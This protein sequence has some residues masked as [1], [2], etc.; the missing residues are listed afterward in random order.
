MKY[1]IKEYVAIYDTPSKKQQELAIV[2]QIINLLNKN[3]YDNLEEFIK[4]NSTYQDFL[5]K[6]N[7]TNVVKHFGNTLKEADYINILENLRKLT[8]SKMNFDK[9]NLTTTNI[10][11][12]E[13]NTYTSENKN[14]F[15]DNSN[16]DKSIEEQMKDLQHTEQK[17]QTSNEKTNTENMLKELE[18]TKKESLNLQQLNQINFSNL[19]Q[20]QKEYFQVALN[21]QISS[22]ETLK[23]D[24]D[25][26][27]I[28]DQNNKIFKIT[29]NE[30]GEYIVITD[31][32]EKKEVNQNEH[33]QQ[34]KVHQKSL[35]PNPNT[36]FSSNNK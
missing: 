36:I 10:E 29:K 31:N 35:K 30:F 5:K 18:K 16:S 9:E 20:Q 24:L 25:R 1:N 17:F 2:S 12:K 22:P 21:Y 27:L 33:T 14:Y 23:I 19:T 3:K 15:I 6:N 11:N 26:G 28:V 4:K 13:Y 34:I 7:M 8:K 32:N